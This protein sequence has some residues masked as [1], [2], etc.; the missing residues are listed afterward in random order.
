MKRT[1]LRRRSRTPRAQLKAK[2]DKLWSAIIRSV[3]HCQRC[4]AGDKQLHAHHLIP[5]TRLAT[6]WA[7]PNGL[8]LCAGCHSMGPASAHQDPLLFAKWFAA[9]FPER[10]EWVDEYRNS[11]A[12]MPLQDIHDALKKY[13]D[14]AGILVG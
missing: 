13:C 7:I 10:V 12:R 8:C 9:K 6:R 11:T 14:E 4:G 5:R 3:G 2:C 1:P